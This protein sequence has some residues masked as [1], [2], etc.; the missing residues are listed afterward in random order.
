MDGRTDGQTDG[1]TDRRTDGWTENIYSIFRDKLLLLGEHIYTDASNY[2]LGACIMQD[3][4]PVAYYSRKLNSAQRNYA[5]FDKELLCAVATLKEFRSMLLG[6]ELHVYTDLKNILNVGNLSEQQLR[7]ISYVDKYGPT[8]HYIEVPCNVILD[9]FSRLL[10]KDVP[11]TLVGKKATHIVSDSELESLYSSLKDNKE[12]LKSFLNL[13]CCFLNKEKE[14][15][16]KN[17]G[18]VLRTHTLWHIMETIFFV[19]PMLNIVISTF[20]RIWLKIIP[21]T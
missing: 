10:R 12:I 11:S 16:P 20:L 21:W 18:N 1:W 15:R 19:I 8:I 7:W 14:E 4:R 2:Q 6:A 5:T 17:A 3:N 13:P 9:T